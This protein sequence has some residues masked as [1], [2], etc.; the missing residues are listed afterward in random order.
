MCYRVIY[1]ST[2]TFIRGMLGL[3]VGLLASWKNSIT[4]ADG[5]GS[6]PCVQCYVSL[7]LRIVRTTAVSLRCIYTTGSIY[8]RLSHVSL[9]ENQRVFSCASVC[10]AHNMVRTIAYRPSKWD[11]RVS[12]HIQQVPLACDDQCS[13]ALVRS[14]ACHE[15]MNVSFS[16]VI[17]RAASSPRQHACADDS[18]SVALQWLHGVRRHGR[19]YIFWHVVSA[20]LDRFVLFMPGFRDKMSDVSGHV[21]RSECACILNLQKTSVT[22]ARAHGPRMRGLV[23][24]SST[25]IFTFFGLSWQWHCKKRK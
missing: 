21:R 3:R 7:S 23:S 1:L 13:N 24:N 17:K 4:A 5:F 2:G 16:G 10:G 20:T 15:R 9:I 8:W 12:C 25:S 11:A 14:C 6:Q 19:R 22:V 18:N